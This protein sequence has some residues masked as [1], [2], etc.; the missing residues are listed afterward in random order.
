MTDRKTLFLDI[1]GCIFKHNGSLDSQISKAEVLPGVKEKF[2]EWTEKDYNIIL[3]TGRRESLREITEKQL[4]EN[5]LY[6]DKLIMGIGNAPRVLINDMK[7]GNDEQT[8]IGINLV[9]NSGLEQVLI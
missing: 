5:N 2:K 3:V 7:L 4:L 9:R 1:D 6:Y 8:A